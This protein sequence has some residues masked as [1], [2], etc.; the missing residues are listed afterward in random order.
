MNTNDNQ[1]LEIQSIWN[2]AKDHVDRGENKEAIEIYKYILIRYAE[3]TIAVEYANAYLG[4]IFLTT[5]RLEQ[6]ETCL[7]KAIEIAPGKGQYHYLL[8]FTYSKKQS[9]NNAIRSFRQA[10]LIEPH[11]AEYERGL[12]WAM[13][14]QGQEIEGLVQLEKAL[15]LCP[16]NVDVLTDLATAMLMLGNIGKARE[17]AERTLKLDPDNGLAKELLKIVNRLQNKPS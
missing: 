17:Y 10:L 5:G 2:E 13:F 12:G 8:G 4:D 6:A 9:W 1:Y 16:S 11:N 7:K 14:N 3:D 15:N